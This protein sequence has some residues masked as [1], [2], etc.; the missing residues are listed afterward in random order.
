MWAGRVAA[1][2]WAGRVMHVGRLCACVLP[3]QA[4]HMTGQK[5]TARGHNKPRECKRTVPMRWC[6]AAYLDMFV[7][8]ELADI[9]LAT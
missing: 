1:C 9:L 2:M 4:V 5:H 3:C 7:A 8:A 6:C